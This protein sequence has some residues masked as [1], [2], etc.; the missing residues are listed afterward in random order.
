MQ[1][2]LLHHQ[3]TVTILL[4]QTIKT[5]I[6]AASNNPL[7]KGLSGRFGQIVFR[8]RHGKTFIS[9]MPCKRKTGPS[10]LE[11]AAREHFKNATIYARSVLADASLKQEYAARAKP[12]QSAYNVAVAEFYTLDVVHEIDSSAYK[13]KQG[14]AIMISI[15]DGLAIASVHVSIS[16]KHTLIEEGAASQLPA[17]LGWVYIS[18]V[19][20]PPI[21]GKKIQVTVTD[22]K[23]RLITKT[24]II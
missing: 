1:Q 18:T 14:N 9:K 22:M 15:A 4:Q 7:T 11:S 17:G 21:A 24:K 10:A 2:T 3:I 23:G 5:N 16:G 19:A 8:Q 12:G 20:D 6:M 13:G